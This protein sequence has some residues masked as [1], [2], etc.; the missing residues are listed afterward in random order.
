MCDCGGCLELYACFAL[1]GTEE[2][3]ALVQFTLSGGQSSFRSHHGYKRSD[4]QV[5]TGEGEVSAKCHSS[6]DLSVCV[7]GRELAENVEAFRHGSVCGVEDGA[8][9][10]LECL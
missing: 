6:Y 8:Q 3:C 2:P 1:D 9:L 5:R 7:A 4:G 10:C